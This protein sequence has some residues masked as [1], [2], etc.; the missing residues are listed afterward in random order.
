[1]IKS[2]HKGFAGKLLVALN[3]F[4]LFLL[5]AG[6]RVVIPEWLQPVGRLHP[7]ILH[8]P[9][10]ILLL[11]ML[12]EFFRFRKEF[13][14]ET[15]YQEFTTALLLTGALFSAI[16][17]I[18]GL[19]LSREA[20]YEGSNLQWHKW[21]GVS[22]AFMSSLI[23]WLRQTAWYNARAAVSGASLVLF[24]IVATGHYGAEIT[25]GDNF[26]LAPVLKKQP[27]PVDKALVYRDVIQPIFES[28]CI[29]C[30]SQDKLKGG[31]MLTDEASIAK[32]GRTG[33]LF[34][35]GQPEI[36]QL[37]QRIHLPEDEKKHMPPAG[38][39]QLSP[40]EMKLLFLWVKENTGFNKKVNELPPDDSLRIIAA[41]YLKPAETAEEKYDFPPADDKIVATLNNN[42]RGI[43]PLSEGSPALAVVVYNKTAY[44]PKVLNE[45]G[46]IK[47][48]IVSL[49]LHKMPVKDQELK[50]IAQFENLR[51]L[52]LNYTDI[53]GGTL[54]DLA[55]LRYLRRLSLAGTSLTLHAFE[56]LNAFKSLRQLTIWNTGLAAADVAWLKKTYKKIQFIEG[57]KDDGKIIK[58]IPPQIKNS[59]FVFSAPIPL[60]LSHPIRGTAIRYTMDG[61]DPDSIKS[62][63]YHPGVMISG[64]AVVKVKAYK[65]GWYGSDIAS[66][67]FYKNTFRPDS[68]R[69]TTIPNE[70]YRAEGAKT[71]T[72]GRLGGMNADNGKW[73]GWQSDMDVMMYFNNPVKLHMLTLNCLKII[74]AQIFLPTELEVWGGRDRRHLKLL[75]M[76]KTA[77]QKKDD[78]AIVKGLTCKLS[79][80]LPLSCIRLIAKPIYKLPKWHYAK[81]KSSWIFADE[82]FL[83]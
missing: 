59:E 21:F 3:I 81:G 68:I 11:A 50:I 75:G 51:A 14:K 74:G 40:A 73:L 22:L 45:L 83:N 41:R 10:V 82:L 9:I 43:Y 60:L 34:I 49:D 66:F 79:S 44:S 80:S 78:P 15:F 47:K 20:G 42:Y 48:Q 71:L 57:Y 28:K 29:A 46:A 38:K 55:A 63:L 25:H 37:L 12:L 27:V 1:M 31:L 39:T 64:S 52:D 17:V 72:D 33:K 4:I 16:T 2:S 70:K 32:G 35:P 8:F 76:V 30:H 6:G 24:C 67:T 53:T 18:M 62:A 5:L 23:Y 19:F 77:E 36:S 13:A 65:E 61:S 58:I 7:V 69:L 54:K 56:Q 26:I